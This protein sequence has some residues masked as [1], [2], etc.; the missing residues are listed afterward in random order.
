MIPTA[1]EKYVLKLYRR[2]KNSYEWESQPCLTFKGK[3]ASQAEVKNYR[4]Q[5]GVNGNTDSIFVKATNLPLEVNVEDR[6]EFLGKF[7]TVKSVG[8]YFDSALFVNPSVFS[9]EKIIA[10]CPKGINLQ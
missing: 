4:V 9:E 6:I 10:R 8:Y 2:I 3:P 7:W 1:D 5:K